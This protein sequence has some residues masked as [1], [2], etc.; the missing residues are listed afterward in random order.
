MGDGAGLDGGTDAFDRID[1]KRLRLR[2]RLWPVSDDIDGD[3]RDE[4]AGDGTAD[5][6]AGRTE[7]DAGILAFGDENI[8]FCD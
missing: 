3:D 1:A 8:T 7:A 2:L 5:E 6:I 4:C